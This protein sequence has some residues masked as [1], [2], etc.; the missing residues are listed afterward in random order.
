LLDIARSLHPGIINILEVGC[1]LGN[2]LEAAKIRDLN[3]LGIDI[4]PYA[5][6]YCL[7]HGLKAENKTLEELHAEGFRFDLI[8]MQ[9]V[10]EH[11]EDPF[12]ILSLCNRLLNQS[13]LLLILV[14]NAGLDT[15]L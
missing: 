13:G 15:L 1:S 2:T 6:Q 14:P 12:L 8:F 5:I 9:H 10:L 7:E 3:S 4:S 11:F